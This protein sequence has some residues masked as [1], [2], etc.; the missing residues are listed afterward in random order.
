MMGSISPPSS[1][2]VD[3]DLPDPE[4]LPAEVVRVLSSCGG[5]LGWCSVPE[6]TSPAQPRDQFRHGAGTNCGDERRARYYRPLRRSRRW[7]RRTRHAGRLV[8]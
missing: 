1:I 7:R 8:V 2:P 5:R 6:Q 3:L 4:P